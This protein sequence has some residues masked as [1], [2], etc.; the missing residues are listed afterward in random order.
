[1]QQIIKQSRSFRWMIALL[2]TTILV[3][4]CNNESAK[5]DKPAVDPTTETKPEGGN[6]AAP[7]V[8][9]TT[10]TKPEGGNQ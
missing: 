9:S 6:Q 2:V 7:A 8:D 10:K 5:T 1:M 4:A 3:F